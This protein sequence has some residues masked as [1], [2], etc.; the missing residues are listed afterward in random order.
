[1]APYRDQFTG[2]NYYEPSMNRESNLSLNVNSHGVSIEFWMKKKE[3]IPTLTNKEVIFDIWNG[4]TSSA[5]NYGRLRL[6]MS[7]A[8]AGASAA[9][10]LLT[11]SSGS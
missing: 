1:M 6:E 5:T 8:S 7:G 10:F 3:F 11:L 4:V 9:P 2:S